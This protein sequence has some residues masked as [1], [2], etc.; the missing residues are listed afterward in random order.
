MIS[1]ISK[2]HNKHKSHLISK[3]QSCPRNP[4]FKYATQ[5]YECAF[6]TPPTRKLICRYGREKSQL[7][8]CDRGIFAI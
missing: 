1:K 7:T 3:E 2:N 6:G 8:F 4:F 5:M